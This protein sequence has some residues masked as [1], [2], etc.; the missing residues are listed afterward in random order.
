MAPFEFP[1]DVFVAINSS[2]GLLESMIVNEVSI[3]HPF[4]SFTDNEYAP[5]AIADISWSV[6]ELDHK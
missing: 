4:P 3:E 5:E 6:E 2:S 1:Q